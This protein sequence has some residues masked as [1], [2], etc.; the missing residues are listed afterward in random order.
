M[1][2]WTQRIN[3]RWRQNIAFLELADEL[4]EAT[5][6]MSSTRRAA[7]AYSEILALGEI[8]IPWLLERLEKPGHRPLW[9]RLLG[10]NTGFATGAG[11]DAIEQSAEAWMHW[12]RSHAR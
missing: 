1:R 5:E 12:G 4:A 11:Q 3:L 6:G 10:A 2:P 7:P 8:T 9:L